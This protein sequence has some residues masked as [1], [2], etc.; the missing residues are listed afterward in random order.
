MAKVKAP[1]KPPFKIADDAV[2]N[3]PAGSNAN[4]G[5][6]ARNKN[7]IKAGG[8][9]GAVALGALTLSGL[10]FLPGEALEKLADSL[11]PFVDEDHRVM[12]L[13][14]CSSSCCCCCIILVCCMIAMVTMGRKN[15]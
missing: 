2:P 7:L 6:F 8:A 12:A 3:K 1:V 15:S 11:F 9:V 4:P 13:G 14:S 10:A 5:F